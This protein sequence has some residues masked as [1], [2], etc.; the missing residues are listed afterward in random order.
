V[1][2]PR[3]GVWRGSLLCRRAVVNPVDNGD[4]EHLTWLFFN[5]GASLIRGERTK[6]QIPS[7]LC[8]ADLALNGAPPRPFAKDALSQIVSTTCEQLQCWA[9]TKSQEEPGITV[10]RLCELGNVKKQRHPAIHNKARA[11][12]CL[13]PFQVAPYL[14]SQPA[15]TDPADVEGLKL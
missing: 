4:L 12:V 15:G 11:A 3:C 9:C 13:W 1:R 6:L 7:P 10:R 5:P 8:W 2:L 14:W